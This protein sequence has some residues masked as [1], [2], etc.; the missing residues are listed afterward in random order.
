M[1]GERRLEQTQAYALTG[2]RHRGCRREYSYQRAWI[3]YDWQPRVAHVESDDEY[4][5]DEDAEWQGRSPMYPHIAWE[6]RERRAH[7]ADMLG[8]QW[9]MHTNNIMGNWD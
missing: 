5:E 3:G 1:C 8:G 7:V 6:R 9:M 4:A 2:P